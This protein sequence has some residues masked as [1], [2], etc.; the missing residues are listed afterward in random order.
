[1]E[2]GE[3][4][5]VCDEFVNLGI[6]RQNGDIVHCPN[7]HK[8]VYEAS[9][10]SYMDCHLWEYEKWVEGRAKPVNNPTSA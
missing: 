3:Y 4:C 5:P 6:P 10:S 1:M 8:L 2:F 9:D 7:G